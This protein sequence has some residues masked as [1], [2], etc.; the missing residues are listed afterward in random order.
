[1]KKLQLVLALLLIILLHSEVYSQ[2]A[3]ANMHMLANKND[4]FTSTLYS[5]VWG[6]VDPHGKE[7][8]IIGCPNGTAFY[9]IS[10]TANI[11]EC[12][13]LPGLT[14]SWREMKVFGKYAYI[15]SEA[16]NSGM[17][18]VNLK[19]LPDS[20]SLISTYLFS[21]YTRTHTISQS[22]PYLYLSGGDYQNSGIF[23]LDI[24]TTPANPVKRGEWET[25]YIHDCRV[26]N[27]TIWG[28]GIF[29]GNIY[30]VDAVNKDSLRSINS[31]PN[32][33]DPGPHNTALSSDGN[34]LFVTD[35][36]NGPSA[37]LLK[38]WNVEDVMNPTLAG[39]WQPTGIPDAIV[40][41]VETYGSIAV[42]AHY[43][44]GVRVINI[45]NPAVPVEL[46]WFDTFPSTNNRTFEGCWGVYMFPSGL[47]AA[48]DRQTGLYILKM[49]SNLVGN[50]NNENLPK[51]YSLKQNYP[52]P[53]NPV[54]KIEYSL[55]ENTHAV[56]KIYDIL[57]KEIATITDKFETAGNHFVIYDA[58]RL[59]SGIY[60]YTLKAGEY[61]STKKMTL[62]K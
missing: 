28:A 36:I 58:S 44:A 31:W 59:S 19:Y 35:E 23:V 53:F 12:D 24:S 26:V 8:A 56:I 50:I 49:D 55:P 41:N 11:V 17:Q 38:I 54:T 14:S 15:V 46:A 22:G 10:D 62:I 6:Y 33:P 7:Y 1:M 2:L 34:F 9:D 18:I 3:N 5:A 4:H 42:V 43:T 40:H 61:V 30:V 13:F 21:G 52:N 37:R 60:F 39:T 51:D 25:E 47:I 32:L 57:G 20:V 45:S 48:S 27:D 29:D 16:T